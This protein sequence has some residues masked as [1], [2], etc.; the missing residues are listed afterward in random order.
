MKA[1]PTPAHTAGAAAFLPALLAIILLCTAVRTASAQE[2]PL[3]TFEGSIRYAG[4]SEPAVCYVIVSR[5]EDGVAIGYTTTD[6]EGHYTLSIR[7]GAD[8]V[9][10]AVSGMSVKTVRRTVPNVSGR[11]DFEVEES[12]FELDEVTVTAPKMEMK[13]DDTVSYNVASFR[14]QEDLVIEDVLRKLPG[15][16]V[17]DNGQILYKAATRNISPDHIASVEILEN[18]QAIKALKDLVPSDKTYINLKL[19]AS[20]RGVFLLSAAAGGG[21][22]DGG[23]WN[24]EAAPMYFGHSSQHILTGKTNNTGDDLAYELEDLTSG[25]GRLNPVLSSATLASPPAIDK[26]RYYR[27]TSYSASLN[28]LFRTSGGTDINLNLSY[29]NDTELR[30]NTSETRWMLP[31]SSVNLIREGISNVIGTDKVNAELSFKSNGDRLYVDNRNIFSAEFLDIASSVNGIGQDFDRTTLRASTTASLIRRSGEK[32]AF[33]INAR[34]AYEHTPYSLA[35]ARDGGQ[36]AG[37]VQDVTADAFTAS[38]FAGNVTSFR[39]WD[40]R[41]EPTLSASYRLG[42]L[43]SRLSTPLGQLEDPSEA[44]NRLMM[45]RLRVAPA[46]YAYY[47]SLHVDLSIFI[48]VAYYMTFL[49]DRLGNTRTSRH[50]VFAEPSVSMKIK[51]A[52]STDINLGYSMSWSMPEI[53]TLYGGAV[54]SD[55]RSLTRYAADLTEGMRNHFSLGLS[56]KDIFNMLFLNL[57]AGYS[58][59]KPDILYGYDFDGIYSTTL[60]TRTGELSHT[61][62]AGIELSKGFYWKDLTAKLELGASWTDSPFLLQEQ[63]AR[64]SMQGY[65]AG[66]DISLSPFKFLG[67][68]YNGS[69]MYSLSRQASGENLTP[70]LTASN[71]LTLSFRLPSDFVL[72]DAALSYKWKRFRWELTCSNLLD[73]REYVYSVLSAASSFSTDYLIR[74]RSYLLKMFVTF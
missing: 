18:H 3:T 54:L 51:P 64:M 45:H 48:P 30:D 24:A 52:A 60:T 39:L 73:T 35:I 19:K 57:S 65:S 69:V 28:E 55:Y 58:L 4:T 46:V 67:L 27:N 37:A 22:G 41:I 8:S 50:K 61:V 56:Y 33:E 53:S 31:D 71:D 32:S 16:T 68:T 49:D 20:S 2:P 36:W 17:R 66:L 7:S 59:T 21:Y 13:G 34:A 44:A 5:T 12:L 72:L 1:R 70:L 62:S 10:I 11:H 26:D 74:P 23:L 63:V 40:M 14:A 47:T 6:G 43:D 9:V 15:I 42:S 25:T 29:L 38:L